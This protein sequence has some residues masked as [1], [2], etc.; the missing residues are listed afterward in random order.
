M[1]NTV[2]KK[3]I[4]KQASMLGVGIVSIFSITLSIPVILTLIRFNSCKDEL[5]ENKERLL[6]YLRYSMTIITTILVTTLGRYFGQKLDLVI[7]GFL[8]AFIG[9][10]N[11]L[12]TLNLLKKESCSSVKDSDSKFMNVMTTINVSLIPIS[13]GALYFLSKNR[14]IEV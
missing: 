8:S 2:N 12:I 5:D 4:I 9:F 10:F 1:A 6:Q 14:V 11:Y 13:I 7:I 3:E